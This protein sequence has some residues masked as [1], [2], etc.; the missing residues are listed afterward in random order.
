M[1]AFDCLDWLGL[2]GFQVGYIAAEMTIQFV[3]LFSSFPESFYAGPKHNC[4]KNQ[5]YPS[6]YCD[7]FSRIMR[8][9][10]VLLL[11]AEA[12]LKFTFASERKGVGSIGSELWLCG[13]RESSLR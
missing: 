6:R 5:S 11:E 1:F 7:R 13:S 10:R 8:S 12:K 2:F 3:V 9:R 4:D